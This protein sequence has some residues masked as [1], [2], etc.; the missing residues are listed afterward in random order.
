[1]ENIFKTKYRELTKDEK[2]LVVNIK[3]MADKLYTIYPKD[4]GGRPANIE[5]SIAITK[6]EESVMWV[7][8]GITK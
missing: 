7:V 8:K 6:L 3:E 4:D 5:I 1:M 2:E